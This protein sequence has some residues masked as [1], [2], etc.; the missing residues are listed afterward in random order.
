MI[1]VKVPFR[2][3]LLGGGTDFPAFYK[4]H[5]GCVIGG[6][7]DK[8]CYITIRKISEVFKYKYRIVWSKN[9]IENKISEIKNPIVNEVLKYFKVNDKIEIHFQADL[10]KN[11]GI[12]SSSSFCVGL[13][14]AI[15]KFKKL[16][17]SQKRM[18]EVAMYIEQIKLKEYCGS[19]DQI[20]ASYGGFRIINFLSNN[21]FKVKN[22]EISEVKKNKLKNNLLLMFTG[23]QRYSKNVEKKKVT[24]LSKNVSHLIQIKNLTLKL[25]RVLESNVNL[26]KV[27][28]LLNEYWHLKK[29][30]AGG[31]S[32]VFIDRLYNRLLKNG[33]TGA[34]LIGS[35]SGGFFL[36]YCDKKKQNKL[37]KQMKQFT[38]LDFNFSKEGSE[39]I[40]ENK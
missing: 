3:S 18:A 21:S 29:K 17:L 4:K 11:S 12:G 25:R 24:N 16:K 13:I 7:I 27:G 8:Y 20:W 39:I 5:G 15:S 23:Y 9:E 2:V 22:I 31:V 40:Y 33:A 37:K 36:L 26:N 19:Q 14:H 28:N 34:K 35:G 38:F 30:L 10:P 32:N 1:I 6:T